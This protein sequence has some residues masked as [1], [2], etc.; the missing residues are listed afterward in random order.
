MKLITFITEAYVDLAHNLYLQL[1]KFGLNT[2]LIVFC[3]NE[4]TFNLFI[5]KK[6]ACEA[7]VY[8]PRL[9]NF[10]LQT[11]PLVKQPDQQQPG[12]FHYSKIISL[13]QDA[14]YQVLLEDRN[15]KY[16]TIIDVDIIIFDNFVE[17][18][19]YYMEY[20]FK[21]DAHG[22]IANFALKYYLN[23]NRNPLNNEWKG[24][25]SVV[26]TGFMCFHNSNYTLQHIERYYRMITQF[27]STTD[28]YNIDETMLTYYIETSNINVV[29]LPD[30][31][32]LCSDTT[33]MY[34][35]EDIDR[36]KA[37]TKTFHVTFTNNKVGF[38]KATNNWH[39][40]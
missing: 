33:H 31:I 12:T 23:N 17:D 35:P 40:K 24:K 2:R 8:V 37:L 14:A 7:R 25:K 28:T 15:N 30:Y 9:H 13:K 21:H 19:I 27:V 3:D 39:V 5:R 32:N 20:P 6:L 26:N 36:I 4:H 11:F 38:M 10:N 16:V 34:Q 22:Q 1:E 18:L 29:D